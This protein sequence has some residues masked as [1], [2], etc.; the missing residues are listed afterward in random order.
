MKVL[1]KIPMFG[2]FFRCLLTE[3][4]EWKDEQRE[5]FKKELE[6]LKNKKVE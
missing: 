5:K 3:S 6:E 2:E 4:S 1:F